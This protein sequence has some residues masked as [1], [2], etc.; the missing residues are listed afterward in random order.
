MGKLENKVALITGAGSGLGRAGALLY[1]REGAKLVLYEVNPDRLNETLEL[2]NAEGI[3][4]VGIVGDV[5]N[6]ED[7]KAA[8]DKTVE[9]Y[10]K[11]DVLV[12]CAGVGDSFSPVGEVTDEEWDLVLGINLTGTKNFSREAIRV[13]LP[14]KSGII[15]NFSSLCGQTGGRQGCAYVASKWAIIGLT[16]NTAAMYSLDGIRCNAI[17]PGGVPTNFMKHPDGNKITK[18]KLYMRKALSGGMVES[19]ARINVEGRLG[20]PVPDEI[21]TIMLF[22]ASDD[23]SLINGTALTADGGWGAY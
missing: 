21:A 3:E 8:V 1:A 20:A 13:M 5:R 16:K 15:I 14:K 9:L 12:N 11:L 18:N 22:L 7:V 4:A 2:F 6:A 23:S 10:G 19:N 17:C